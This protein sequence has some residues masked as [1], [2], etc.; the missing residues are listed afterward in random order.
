MC[1]LTE[2]E[3]G[4]TVGLPRHRHLLEFFNVPVKAPT[5]GQS[6]KQSHFSRLL[7]CALGYGG[8]IFILNPR[9]GRG[10]QNWQVGLETR[11]RFADTKHASL[12]G[13]RQ[14]GAVHEWIIYKNNT[15]KPNWM[16]FRIC[17]ENIFFSF[18]N[19]R[20]F[21]QSEGCEN[22]CKSIIWNRNSFESQNIL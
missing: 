9:G 17:N 18:S 1:R 11:E 20:R 2:E 4:P 16:Y 6:E 22:D 8:H 14:G 3:I 15:R 7:R 12:W 21:I 19:D 10:K 5:R 13:G